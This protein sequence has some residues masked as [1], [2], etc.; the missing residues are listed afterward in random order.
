LISKLLSFF[1]IGPQ[2]D[3]VLQSGE[4][5]PGETVVGVFYLKGGLF[6][7]RVKRLEC[8]LVKESLGVEPELV[9]EVTT[10]L[11]SKTITNKDQEEV[12]FSYEIPKKIKPTNN[13]TSYRF[14]TLLVLKNNTQSKDFDEIVIRK[15]GDGSL[16]SKRKR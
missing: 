8:Y 12:Q 14:H 4:M 16:A 3:L 2:V 5:Q 9:D 1:R 7:H 11:M 13:T 15:R 10:I 6:K